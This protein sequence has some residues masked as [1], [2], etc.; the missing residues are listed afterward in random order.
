VKEISSA[1]RLFRADFSDVSYSIFITLDIISIH[2]LPFDV[3]SDSVF[4]TFDLLSVHHYFL[5]AT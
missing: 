1:D 2:Y 4:I 3:M 5:F